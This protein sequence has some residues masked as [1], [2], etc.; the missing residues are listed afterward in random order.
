MSAKTKKHSFLGLEIGRIGWWGSLIA[1]LATPTVA[2]PYMLWFWTIKGQ[3]LSDNPERWAQ[4]GDYLAGT[5]GPIMGFASI[6]LLVATLH[7]QRTELEE[8]RQQLVKSTQEVAEQNRILLRQSF[9]QTFFTW[10]SS[11]KDI[12]D[13]FSY[14]SSAP[15]RANLTSGVRALANCIG[16][17]TNVNRIA[18]HLLSLD[19]YRCIQQGK[20]DSLSHEGIESIKNE[21]M[22]SW[23]RIFQTY[24]DDLGTMFRT[25][26]GLMRWVDEHPLLS[27]DEKYHYT[28]IA[29]A[30][31][32]NAELRALFLNGWTEMGGKFALLI[33]KYAVFDNL[34]NPDVRMLECLKRHSMHP[35]EQAAYS[36]D[37]AA[38]L[39]S[40][41]HKQDGSPAI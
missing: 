12:V 18:T 38:A 35:Y 30:Q 21:A 3:E 41:R 15:E 1:F 40:A 34:P 11:Y 7:L 32:S 4:F 5:V 20:I 33:N 10:L 25:L 2:L 29:R 8:Q 39:Q 36:S 13:R 16:D 31:L 9:E 28:S 19:D 6:M 26:Y 22:D 24:S 14:P 17:L 23:R 27:A 37:I